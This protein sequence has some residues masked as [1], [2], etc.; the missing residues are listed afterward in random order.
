[1]FKNEHE[2][3]GHMTI[4]NGDAI[5]FSWSVKLSFLINSLH[6]ISKKTNGLT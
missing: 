2:N 3:L 4:P 1:M 5:R 6:I